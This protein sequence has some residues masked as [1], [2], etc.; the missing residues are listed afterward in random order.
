MV[1]SKI[2]GFLGLS[3]ATRSIRDDGNAKRNFLQ[4]RRKVLK[5][6]AL[7]ERVLLS[8]VPYQPAIHPFDGLG[9]HQQSLDSNHT[10]AEASNGNFSVVWNNVQSGGI[11]TQLFNLNSQALTNPTLVGNSTSA[12]SQETISCDANG[13]VVVAWTHK[14]SN[15]STQ[16]DAQLFNPSGAPLISGVV[17]PAGNWDNPSV[18][19][20]DGSDFLIAF[21][22][23]SGGTPLVQVMHVQ[24][25]DNIELETTAGV[26]V[27]SSVAP[28]LAANSAGIGVLAYTQTV[29]T[30]G[31]L[32]LEQKLF[33][34]SASADGEPGSIDISISHSIS[35][36]SVG[37]DLA[38]DVDVAY[39]FID[40]QTAVPGYTLYQSDVLIAQFNPAGANIGNLTLTN[41]TDYTNSGYSPSLTM[42]PAGNMVVACEVGDSSGFPEG[43]DQNNLAAQAYS[44]SGALLQS[45]YLP[46]PNPN[47]VEDYRP[48]VTLN[49]SGQLVVSF[50][51]ITS[52]GGEFPVY[53]PGIY[54]Q[55][56]IGEP[57]QYQLLGNRI[58]NL[59][60]GIPSSLEL[61]D[62]TP[63]AGF[64]ASQISL[65]FQT[66][67][68]G[69]SATV[70]QILTPG[71]NDFRFEVTL[72]ADPNII[73]SSE[74][75]DTSFNLTSAGYLTV[76]SPI[77]HVNITP[78]FISDIYTPIT[79]GYYGDQGNKVLLGYPADI[80]GSGFIPGST[81]QFTN[82]A[83]GT[84]TVTPTSIS[85]NLIVVTVPDNTQNGSTVTIRRPGG[86]S[87]VSAPIAV[88]G[89]IISSF[90]TLDG[91]APGY[92]PSY[93]TTGS[94][95]TIYG[96]GFRP[97]CQVQFGSS[98]TS[99]S[100]LLA[101][102]SAI[103][104]DGDWLIVHIPSSAVTGPVYV[105][106]QGGSTTAPS[107]QKFTV[108]T[109]RNTFAF[110]FDNDHGF[111]VSQN[112]MEGEYPG[113]FGLVTAQN[114]YD[115]ALA[116]LAAGAETGLFTFGL[117]TAVLAAAVTAAAD[118]VAADL[119]FQKTLLAISKGIESSSPGEC[120]GF[121]VAG[122]LLA[123]NPSMLQQFY[124]DQVNEG[125]SP[126]KSNPT[127]N[128]LFLTPELETYIQENFLGQ[129]SDQV[130]H[131]G[132]DWLLPD[133]S[134][135][136]VYGKI[137]NDLQQGQHPLIA[138]L[139]AG[140]CVYAYNLEPGILG[141]GD[142]YIDV[143]DPNRPENKSED[144]DGSAH[145]T[146]FDAS[147][148][149]IIPGTGWSFTMNDGKAFNGGYGSLIVLPP[150]VEQP[151]GGLKLPD[152][153]TDV[154]RF[155]F[156]S[157]DTIYVTKQPAA[158]IA[159]GTSFSVT[160]THYNTNGTVNTS[161]NG[162][163]TI[164]DEAGG[165]LG[166]TTTVQAVNGVASFTGLTLTQA[167]PDFLNISSTGL[168]TVATNFFT[169]QAAPATRL[170][171]NT[172]SGS[173]VLATVTAV[174]AYGNVD[175]NFNG[176][177]TLSLLDN[178]TGAVLYEGLATAP[179]T[180]QAAAGV[181]AV[182]LQ[183]GT[184]GNGYTLQ[185]TSAGLSAGTSTPFNVTAGAAVVVT[186]PPNP[187]TAG[188]PFG[189][190]AS[191]GNLLFNGSITVALGPGGPP[192]SL[193][194]TLTVPVVNG[195]ANFAGLTLS[196]AGNFNLVLS[197]AGFTSTSIS[198]VVAGGAATHLAITE[199]PTAITTGTGFNLTVAAQDAFGNADP[200]FS[201]VISIRLAANP[202]EAALSG[203][204]SA[205]ASGGVATFTGLTL[206]LPGNSFTIQ[207][208]A[209][210]LALALSGPIS[211]SSP[212]VA[213]QLV[214][215]SEP[216]SAATA[217][218]GFGLVV[219]AQDSL[220]TTDAN[221]NGVV[222]ITNPLGGAPLAVA[223]AVN[224][225]AAFT[226]VTINQ[227]G[228]YLLQLTARGLADAVASPIQISPAAATQ[229]SVSP[230]TSNVITAFAFGVIVQAED[231]YGN[232]DPTYAGNVTLILSGG[233]TG[234]TLGG[235]L[236]GQAFGGAAVFTSLTINSPGS[237][238]Q[239]QAAAT[240][241]NSGSTSGFNVSSRQLVIANDPP[242]SV[243]AG[244]GFGLEVVAED[245]N[246][247]LDT[248][249]NG[250]VSIALLSP[251][252]C[253]QHSAGQ[254][255]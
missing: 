208:S 251:A 10:I 118:V 172:S 253:A 92:S 182:G 176:T 84:W 122:L 184:P 140:H 161:F 57:F 113:Q 225:V 51:D 86:T 20:T 126:P 252:Q 98:T 137:L 72:T 12:D 6:Q 38:G 8:I 64:T 170:V 139:N 189:M 146:T 44:S 130:I 138:L 229:L 103:S 23:N 95:V 233:P 3:N 62:I 209:G 152:S 13:D 204:L 50:V 97:G 214:V 217:G 69:V 149:H 195:Y 16:V 231:Q 108:H 148:I 227:A 221:F 121:D 100:S 90:S 93:L 169:V 201:G 235:T 134:D 232:V 156:G 41:S 125:K 129:V 73:L 5:L 236:T 102:P 228:S 30:A 141:N 88:T 42:D 135:Q 4:K 230:P 136:V 34:G 145:I 247:N 1:T 116:A 46:P 183:V 85:Q 131:A 158:V 224:G 250:P 142:Y 165:P 239:L 200:H 79:Y 37:I 157:Q 177:E 254:R 241:L 194:G 132:L 74:S 191:A 171:V 163:D 76:I 115:A 151:P 199:Q 56:F 105:L 87:L 168:T 96:A 107:T 153:L 32:L 242:G 192:T 33:A 47:S 185:A 2:G 196:K 123:N 43:Y 14:D 58:I 237:G 60:T 15:G 70:Q 216:P 120:Y 162:F 223:T 11:Y 59:Y 202:A 119:V 211:A 173:S 7:E 68:T 207:A 99:E 110:S 39:T 52:G 212:G 246:G 75:F 160:V 101:T 40:S 89:P 164:A 22:S 94:S 29:G 188:A 198:V 128:D 25:V 78:S 26:S 159:A 106:N 222:S 197:G 104:P 28:S 144:M 167:G 35:Q 150:S 175:T 21:Q 71:N 190:V 166:G 174:D 9:D 45:L 215:T 54:V 234:V 238:F 203:V 226:G 219:K 91:Y 240:G 248:S 178:P 80:S 249:F 187:V 143:Y 155:L 19:M 67:P 31:T 244:N 133:Q 210:S 83:G 49:T 245:G 193:G 55:T 65:A 117:S 154:G 218:S 114:E 48:S 17:S 205:A 63:D 186:S 127:V 81:V 213:S 18:S 27:A 255:H 180:V 147:R 82:S 220:G 53:A 124:Q 181:A 243:A 206:N 36:A 66:L 109:Y 61:L 77:F 179:L 111:D 112:L 24:N